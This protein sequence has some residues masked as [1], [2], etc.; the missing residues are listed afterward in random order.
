IPYFKFN[1]NSIKAVVK[2]SQV[3]AY[4]LYFLS[5]PLKWMGEFYTLVPP[6]GIVHQKSQVSISNFL[7]IERATFQV[8]S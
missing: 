2:F 3:L 7:K 6:E 5:H 4:L 1:F 8:S